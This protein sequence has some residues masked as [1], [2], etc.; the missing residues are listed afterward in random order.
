MRAIAALCA[1]KRSNQG[2]CACAATHENAQAIAALMNRSRFT[3]RFIYTRRFGPA[4]VIPLTETATPQNALLTKRRACS[5]DL[6]ESTDHAAK[7]F[8]WKRDLT[9]RSVK[10]RRVKCHPCRP[11]TLSGS[12]YSPNRMSPPR[13][14]PK[15]KPDAAGRRKSQRP[16]AQKSAA[17]PTGGIAGNRPTVV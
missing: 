14:K 10:L 2:C 5:G 6:R 17:S 12:S 7:L 13:P 15:A 9:H 4:D 8:L 11:K 16:G 1:E 3:G